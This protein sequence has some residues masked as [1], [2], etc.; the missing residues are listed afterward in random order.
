MITNKSKEMNFWPSLVPRIGSSLRGEL[1]RNLQV[2]INEPQTSPGN[3]LL[4]PHAGIESFSQ[5]P[6]N[7]STA[8]NVYNGGQDPI[9]YQSEVVMR[10]EYFGQ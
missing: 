2:Q 7:I 5:I 3:N 10:N 1:Q 4:P 9:G 6:Q 8:H